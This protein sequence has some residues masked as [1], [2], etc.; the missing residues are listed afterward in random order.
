MNS[1]FQKYLKILFI[2]LNNKIIDHWSNN[3]IKFGKQPKCY[4]Y[5]IVPMLRS[6]CIN[7]S[8]KKQFKVQ[9]ELSPAIKLK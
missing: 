3:K 9:A 1:A 6:Y 8:S 5:P 4:V 2:S 7:N